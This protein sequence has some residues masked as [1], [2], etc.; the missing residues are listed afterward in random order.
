MRIKRTNNSSQNQGEWQ[1]GSAR[2]KKLPEGGGYVPAS[3]G[4]TITLASFNGIRA[5]QE[6]L[7]HMARLKQYL[8]AETREIA[9]VP[10]TCYAECQVARWM[11]SEMIKECANSKLIESVCERCKEFHEIAS[12]SVVHVQRNQPEPVSIVLQSALD[13]QRASKSFQ[14]ALAE[15]HVECRLNQ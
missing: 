9:E 2:R 13:L 5:I 6:H 10:L 8:C 11:H 1:M 15:L 7:E 14:Q 4:K 12:Q 3:G